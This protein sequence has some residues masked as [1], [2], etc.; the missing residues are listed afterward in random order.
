MKI[1]LIDSNQK[2]KKIIRELEKL[3]IENIEI[4]NDNKFKMTKNDFVIT[5]D[6][7]PLEGLEK[8]KNIIFLMNS[9][10]Y[11]YAWNMANNY[12]TIDLIDLNMPEEYIAKRIKNMLVKEL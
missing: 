5:C 9:K 3:E 4:K 6:E 11:K 12:K 7:T 2:M 10:D 8:L 1:Y